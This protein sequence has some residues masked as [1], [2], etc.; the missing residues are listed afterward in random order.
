MKKCI[1]LSILLIC[2]FTGGYAFAQ[3]TDASMEVLVTGPDKQ[4]IP[5]ATITVINIST[6]FK[7]G[8][9]SQT[10]G[11]YRFQQLP[12][13]GPYKVTATFI[14][15]QPSSKEG[16]M[17]NQG[18]NLKINL[19]LSEQASTLQEVTI[20]ATGFRSR[21]ERLGRSTAI[22]AQEIQRLP[23]ANRDFTNLAQ[24]SPMVGSSLNI[25]GTN[26]RNDA[27]TVDGVTSKESAFGEANQMPY[28]F[29]IEALREFE[30]VTNSYDVTEGRSVAGGIKAVTKSGTNEFHGSV[31]SYFWDNRL[32]AQTDLLGRNVINDT[33]NQRGF[34]LG[35]PLLKDKL[36]FFIS[37]DGQRQEQAY[38]LWSQS[39]TPGIVQ[40]NRG[41][42]A[43]KENLDQAIGILQQKYGVP[44]QPQYGFFTRNNK[45][46]TY[47]AK[48]DWQINS[49]H[50]LTARYNQ[51]DFLQPSMANSDIGNYGINSASYNFLIKNK[52]ALLSLR[53]Q[54]NNNLSNELKVGYYFNTRQN[55]LTTAP[56]PQLWLNMQSAING[57][58]QNATLVGYYNRWVPE[59]QESAIYSF[60]DDVYLNKGRF[61]FVFG[62]Q[63]TFTN[64][65]GIYTHDIKGRFDFNSIAA[66]DAMQPDR[67]TRK[68]TNPN[69]E[70]TEPLGTNLAELAVYAQA[71]TNITPNLK[72]TAGLRY[73]VSIFSTA[74]DY[75]P[76]LERELGYRNNVKPVDANN[77][78]PR[79]NINWDVN[80]Q[81]RDIIDGG[82]GIFAGQMVTRP[83]IYG[84]I[85]NGI[86]FTGIDITGR[87]GYIL[88]PPTGDFLLKDGQRVPMPSPD[89]AAFREGENNIPGTGYTRS[90]LFG[91]GNE[92]QVVRFVDKNLQL[93]TSLK[94]HLSYHHYFTDW[95]RGGVTAYYLHTYNMLTMENANLTNQVAFTLQG[96]GGREVYTPLN[97]MKANAANF[98]GAKIS[99]QFTDALRFTNGYETKSRGIILDAAIQ[100][101][102]EGSITL[103]YTRAQAKGAENY[104]NE[105]DQRFVGVSYFDDYNFI[106]N[107]YS[108]YDF[109]QKV[110]VN[111][112]TT[113]VGGFTFG[114]FLNMVE[115]GRFSAIISPIDVMGTNI[116]DLNGY[117]AYIFNPNAPETVSFQGEQ[118]VQDLKTVFQT[119]GPAAQKYLNDN[120]G[121]YAQPYGGLMGWRTTLN[122]RIN[123]DIQLYKNHKL[124]INIDA[125]NVLNLLNKS[126]GGYWNYP[127]QELYKVKTF[128]AARQSYEYEVNKNFGQR[129]KEGNGFLLMFGAKYAF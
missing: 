103:S 91:A 85:D 82:L 126:W 112:T 74:P 1:S 4:P 18:N 29:S 30:V 71:T 34:T 5:G 68:F 44:V 62:T 11:L 3:G 86:R 87:E 84:L 52:N 117:S 20:T 98:S 17:L 21:D 22:N 121:Q 2:L 60:T 25:G 124:I 49:I 23:S 120:I 26:S 37:Y 24:L 14:G 15:Y 89:Y 70:L 55:A 63:N 125:F 59:I 61:N 108:P 99:Q 41:Q 39:V 40:N 64:T 28:T 13:G 116:R 107:G 90:E 57:A 38:D 109:R 102:H 77:I 119:A 106:N 27:F 88:D 127:F 92:A 83:Y 94:G 129:R 95:L 19:A 122:A 79:L 73:D 56:T 42:Q 12:L 75:N 80:G 35:G 10:N 43:T 101:P 9:A 114:A 7:T 16:F 81:R 69:Q 123:N 104:R 65:S 36:H 111:I 67:F 31:F 100:L 96:E 97:Q 33:K 54:L 78:Q 47:F 50:T 76:T 66:L 58:N 46:N 53:S 51:S 93:P 6:G 45:L 32:G 8:A 110:L 115:T 48:V 72:A 105:D 118:F 128:N 113:K